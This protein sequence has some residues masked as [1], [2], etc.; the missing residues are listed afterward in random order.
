M[1]YLYLYVGYVEQPPVV[2]IQ[3]LTLYITCNKRSHRRNDI[4]RTQKLCDIY[5][6]SNNKSLLM[7]QH[8]QMIRQNLVFFYCIT[9]CVYFVYC[10][11]FY[12]F[13]S[14]FT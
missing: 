14:V 4:K 5:I 8:R 7:F 3:Q 1:L 13:V 10:V 9:H 11:L 12:P 6:K 2:A